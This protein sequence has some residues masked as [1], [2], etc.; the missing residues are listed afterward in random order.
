GMRELRVDVRELAAFAISRC[1]R[2]KPAERFSAVTE[3]VP[4]LSAADDPGS[5]TRAV[6]WWRNH[7]LIVLAMYFLASLAAWQIKEWQHG[8][9]DTAFVAIAVMSTIVGIFRGHLL[10]T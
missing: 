2:K 8:V 4:A 3:I 7:Q 6:D 5:S 10:F 9:A 1:L